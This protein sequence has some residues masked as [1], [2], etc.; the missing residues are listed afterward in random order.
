[1]ALALHTIPRVHAIH[2]FSRVHVSV[3][4]T[5]TRSLPAHELS[6]PKYLPCR[7]LAQSHG[8][9]AKIGFEKYTPSPKSLRKNCPKSAFQP[10]PSKFDTFLRIPRES[11][12]TFQNQSLHRNR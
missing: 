6:A 11:V 2:L 7:I 4:I 10:K 3:H 12:H 1:M 8:F 5:H 9:N